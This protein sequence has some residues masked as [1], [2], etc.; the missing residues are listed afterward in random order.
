MSLAGN[1]AKLEAA[2]QLALVA[3]DAGL[4]LVELALGFALEHPAVTS[5]IIGPRTM[6]QLE[7]YLGGADARLDSHILDRIDD[8]VPPG[9]TFNPADVGWDPPALADPGARRR[10]AQGLVRAV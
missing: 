7:A 1:Q 3:E 8:I 6:E 5:V 10:A 4:G 9:T 2:E